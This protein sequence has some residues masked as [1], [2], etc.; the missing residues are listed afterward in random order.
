MSNNLVEIVNIPDDLERKVIRFAFIKKHSNYE[1]IKMITEGIPSD[2]T[3]ISENGF[4]VRPIEG[5]T[6][7]DIESKKT[8]AGG[9]YDH[10]FAFT[11][12]KQEESDIKVIEKYFLQ[13]G[14]LKIT[15]STHEYIIGS[16]EEPL[17]YTYTEDA[18]SIKVKVTGNQRRK[19]LRKKY[20]PF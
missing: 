15:T 9:Y 4:I 8:T 17:T 3:L 7:V 19:P 18:K 10:Q 2:E 13:P 14:I 16:Y 1:Y 6:N 20:S 11:I 5:D 12:D